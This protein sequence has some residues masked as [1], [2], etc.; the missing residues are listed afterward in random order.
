MN[1]QIKAIEDVGEALAICRKSFVAVAVFSFCINV[2]MLTPLFYMINV[3]DKAVAT[4]SLPTLLSLATVAAFLYLVMGVLEWVRSKVLVHV[5]TR[6][7][8]LLAPRI[9]ELCF[10]SQ[11]GQAGVTPVGSQPLMELNA[12]RQFMAGPSVAVL[13][14]VPWTPLFILI[15][16]FFHP[17]LAI[18]AIL[19]V[20][21]MAAVAIANQRA[22]TGKLQE[23]NK[24]A[25]TIAM[26]NQSNLRNAEAVTALGMIRPLTERW[27]KQ[28]DAMLEVQASASSVASGY[29][30]LIKT[31][32][33]AMQSAAITT[34]A[35]LA[36][37]QEI[38]PGVIIGAA[39]LLGKTLQPIQQAVSGWKGFVDAREQYR[40][41]NDLLQSFPPPTEKMALP[42]IT[43][44]ITASDIEVA[45]PGKTSP[46]L[47][48]LSFN[49]D[50]G[51]TVMIVGPS[52]SGKSTLVRAIL[53]LWPTLK[54][55]IRIDGSE[56][57]Y[58]DSQ[59]LGQQVGYLP[60]GIELFDG[61]VA[62]NIARFNT[63]DSDAVILAAKEAGIHE[64][65]LSLPEGY[66]TVLGP[67]G[68]RLSPGQQQRVALARAIYKKPR[69][70]VMDE[71]N[72]N[73]D[74]AGEK[75]LNHAISVLKAAGSTV[76]VVSHRQ[77]VIPLADLIIVINNG[78][79]KEQLSK[80]DV[81]K[82]AQA[83]KQAA[84]AKQ[85][86]A[87]KANAQIASAAEGASGE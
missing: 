69:L 59:R 29:T 73:L 78:L 53:G 50:A 3:Y 14:D 87:A 65:M 25:A 58:F 16:F 41:I 57:R 64:L 67:G 10:Y 47:K 26:R 61:S 54:G 52:G 11:S 37:A 31:L 51:K 77:T 28:Q 46:I 62:E 56:A 66:D 55:D 35:V 40:K 39:L 75:A 85:T 21:I 79:I 6:L 82:R 27:R 74:E 80:D 68:V 23:A 1:N 4:G 44:N 30:A 5:G 70:V 84:V 63:P 7:D 45:A 34:G 36:M 76:V 13:F 9:Y 48:G 20:G 83:A 72:S 42:D 8:L 71:P 49:I 86:A 22:T 60:Q 32:S 12:L 38:T 43:G 17:V 18:V 33:L 15:M 2:L 19:C 81:I 24:K